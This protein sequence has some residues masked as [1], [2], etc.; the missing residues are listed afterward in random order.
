MKVG[1]RRKVNKQTRNRYIWAYIFILPQ[2][3]VFFGLSLYPIIM[4]YVYSFYDWT[5]IGPLNKFV[6]FSN[7]I[8][9]FKEEKFWNA[10]KNTF[11][12]TAGFTMVSVSAALVLA[13]ILNNPK[14]K[15]I[16]IYRTIYFLPVVTTTAIIG[17]IMK[18]IFGNQGLINEAL[19]IIGVIDQAVPWLINP[20]TAMIVLIIVGSWKEIGIIMIYWLTGLQMIP[21]ELYE[22]AHIDGAGYWQTLRHITLPLLAPIGA[23]IILLTTVSSMH[24]FDL[25]KTLTG[26][27]PYYSTETLE[28]YIYRFAFASD[29]ISQVGY[30]STVGVILGLTVF[31]ISLG[32]GWVVMRVNKSRAD[33]GVQ[34]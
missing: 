15:G 25:V 23:T 32:L 6:G 26:G 11:I 24:V 14:L 28:L 12:Y 27:G 3:I 31:I 19:K 33:A 1:K 18:N 7:Y 34:G 10:F 5:G 30:A 17:I 9:V 29:G 13:L 21:R 22:A 2:F 8:S 20:V 16:G 4:S